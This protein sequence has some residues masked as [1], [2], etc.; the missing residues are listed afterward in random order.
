MNI[1]LAL[2]FAYAKNTNMIA[3]KFKRNG[4]EMPELTNLSAFEIDCS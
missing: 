1:H 2:M 3:Q 4:Q